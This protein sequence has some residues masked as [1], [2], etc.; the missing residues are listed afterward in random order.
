MKNL[1]LTTFLSFLMI[2][3]N[4]LAQD[5][6]FIEKDKTAPFSGIL[7]TEPKAREIRLQLLERDAF[8]KINESLEKSLVAVSNNQ[9]VMEERIQAYKTDNDSLSKELRSSQSF[10]SWEKLIWFGLGVVATSLAVY[11][12]KQATK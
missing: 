3:N 4:G 8:I 2:V 7:F 5:A 10:T 9:K 11:G 12:T 6:V 1:L